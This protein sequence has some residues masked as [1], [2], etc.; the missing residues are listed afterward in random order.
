MGGVLRIGGGLSALPRRSF[1]AGFLAVAGLGLGLLAARAPLTVLVGVLGGVA[2][3][4]ASFVQP[5]LGLGLALLVGPSRAWLEIASPGIAPH[6]GQLVLMVV[7]LAWV[8]RL[9]WLREKVIAIPPATWTLVLFIFVGLLSLLQP[10]DLWVGFL[11]WVKWLQILLVM[12]LAFDRIAKFGDRGIAIAVAGLLGSGLVQAAI[13]LWQFA[14]RGEGVEQFLIMGRFYRA[15]GTFQQPNPYAGLIGL[16][17]AVSA[18]LTLQALADW[19]REGRKV[20]GLAA[21][22]VPAVPTVLLI[23]GL[24]ASWSR[25]GWMGFAA[26][27][28]TMVALVPRRGY[29]GALLVALAFVAGGALFATGRLPSS[30]VSRLTGFLS[31]VQFRDVRGSDVTNATFAVMERLAHWQAA[32]GM[33]RDNFWLGVGL[34]CYEPAYPAYRL[35]NWVFPLGHAHNAYLNVAAETGLLGLLAYGVWGGGLLYHSVRAVISSTGWRRGLALGLL[36]AW[37]HFAAHSLVD[38]LLVN[39]VHMHVAVLA[40]LTATLGCPCVVRDT[41][42]IVRVHSGAGQPPESGLARSGLDIL[43]QSED[44]CAIAGMGQR[45]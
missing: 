39:N 19:W 31:Y 35:I 24:G 37:V 13:G 33:W 9:L 8:V 36:G 4:V 11:E 40:A 2:L 5:L 3:V 17:G 30:I 43:G 12:C 28:L 22:C 1:V 41:P 26:A 6:I 29:W 23:V 10:A 7:L 34:G 27:L 42:G 16:V 20:S 25:G 21:V 14:I 32:L 18:G 45:A 44:E 38:N 15:Y